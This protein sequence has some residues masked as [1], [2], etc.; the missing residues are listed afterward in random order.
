LPI[1]TKP[2]KST[3][4]ILGEQEF[5][6]LSFAVNSHVLIPRPETEHL[7]D[8]VLRWL[9]SQPQL[10][11]RVRIV[12]LGAGSGCI[13]LS[14]LKKR[15]D[16]QLLAVDVS[17]E[18]L[19]VLD[20]NAKSLSVENRTSILSLKA[21]DLT[22]ADLPESF[23]GQVDIVVAN[24][25]Y[26]DPSDPE[27]DQWVKTHEPSL[28]LF[29]DEGGLGAIRRWS[30]VAAN[31]LRPGGFLVFEIGHCQGIAAKKL[32][33]EISNLVSVGIG[34]DYSGKDRYVFAERKI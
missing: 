14:L 7:V 12:D 30:V 3:L 6:G 13:G 24:P 32:L 26:I 5:Y 1:L 25:P 8:E 22:L 11:E 18:A 19:D 9:S 20:F 27:V 10:K 31:L 34:K 28:A 23:N 21:E 2:L 29:S 16:A 15:P 4:A 33:G 17:V